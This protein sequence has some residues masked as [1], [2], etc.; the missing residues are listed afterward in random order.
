MFYFHFTF[1]WIYFL[2]SLI[3]S[4]IHWLFGNVV[5]NLQTFV[6]FPLFLSLIT[7][8]TP[9]W[10]EKMLSMISMFLNLLR[11]VLWSNLSGRM[12]HKG[13]EENIVCSCCL[14]C[15]VKSTWY[16]NMCSLNTMF[17][18]WFSSEIYSWDIRMVNTYKSIKM[19]YYNNKRKN[20]NWTIS[21]NTKN[22]LNDKGETGK[23]FYNLY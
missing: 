15:S 10:S 6:N 9:L 13:W 16:N 17:L 22:E 18:Y 1:V 4:L 20:R 23:N 2:F 19:I 5:Y 12:F 11:L 21:I 14:Q 8:F 3:S 7:Y